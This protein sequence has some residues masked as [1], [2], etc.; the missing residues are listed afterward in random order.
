MRIEE[1]M[2]K[3]V[4]VAAPDS[5]VKEVAEQLTRYGFGAMPVVDADGRL[6]GIITEADLLTVEVGGPDPRRHVRRDPPADRPAPR[7]A[8]DLMSAPVVAARVGTDVAEVAQL[9]LAS[10]LTRVPVLDHEDRL[11]GLVSRSDLIK[12]LARPDEEIAADVRRVLADW[13]AAGTA[14][15]RVDDGEVTLTTAGD[16]LPAEIDR[17]V[18]AVPGVIALRHEALDPVAGPRAASNRC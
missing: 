12:P 15:V 10:H 2:T 14:A 9:M 11:V 13:G 6:V 4:L 8:A 1:V 18:R 5:S 17:L 16:R 3:P 7:T